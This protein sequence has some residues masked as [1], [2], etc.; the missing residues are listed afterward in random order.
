MFRSF[1]ASSRCLQI[2]PDQFPG[3]FQKISRIHFKKNSGRFLR[4]KPYNIKMQVKFVMSDD[5]LC[6]S[7][8]WYLPGRDAN[9]WDHSDPAYA[10]TSLCTVTWK[11]PDAQKLHCS[12]QNFQGASTKFQYIFS[13]SRSNFK[14][15]EISRLSR[16]CTHP[17]VCLHCASKSCDWGHLLSLKHN[18]LFVKLPAVLVSLFSLL[19]QLRFQLTQFIVHRWLLTHSLAQL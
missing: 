16:S 9:P 19:L 8:S 12:L 4:D 5:V 14:F 6:L 3:D 2:Q 13:I 7:F 18:D 10:R 11:S 1:C 17:E 15:Q